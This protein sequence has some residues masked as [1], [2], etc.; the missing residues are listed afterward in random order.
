MKSTKKAIEQLREV[1]EIFSHEKLP[2]AVAKAY[3]ESEGKPSDLWSMG[4]KILMMFSNTTDARGF[5]QWQSV[6]RHVKKGARAIYI[7]G[8]CLAV[9]RKEDAEDCPE[10]SSQKE[11]EPEKTKGKPAADDSKNSKPGKNKSQDSGR[12]KSG[13]DKSGRDESQDPESA[14][15][16]KSKEDESKNVPEETELEK[17]E[18]ETR[19]ILTGF[20]CIPVF[21]YEDTEGKTL[22]TVKNE[23]KS[24]PPLAD[25]AKKWGVKVR[26]DG[27]SCGE[28]GSFS[29]EDNEIR[30]CTD[31]PTT[32][33]HE[34]SHKAHDRIEKLKPGQ[35]PEQEAIAQLSACVLGRLYGYN[36]D[37]YTHRYI[38]HYA[39]DGSPERVG[40][41]CYRV[42]GK[43]EAVLRMILG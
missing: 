21:R 16:D 19:T 25:V 10:N 28:Y 43:T 15:S 32:F 6:G 17:P 40:R 42:L 5:R 30:L 1:A 9:I 12:M 23:P 26:Y 13:K 41:M 27:T 24:L 29:S 36:A 11:P 4:N 22:K 35:D 37:Q 34:L 31:D 18:P 8:P 38:A 20:R 39:G 7:L 3:L 33:F 14:K 2:A